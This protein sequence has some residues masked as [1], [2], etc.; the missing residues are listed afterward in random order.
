MPEADLSQLRCAEIANRRPG[1]G[2][3]SDHLG[4]PFPSPALFR[5]LGEGFL[6]GGDQLRRDNHI[7]VV[8]FGKADIGSKL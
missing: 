8:R 4:Y 2:V 7:P 5:K 3:F 6:Q 1:G